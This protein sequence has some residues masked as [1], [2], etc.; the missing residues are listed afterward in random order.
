MHCCVCIGKGAGTLEEQKGLQSISENVSLFLSEQNIHKEVVVIER[1]L[2]KIPKCDFVFNLCDNHEGYP[3]SFI[4]FTEYLEQLQIPYTGNK[5]SCFKKCYDKFLWSNKDKLKDFLPER[6]CTVSEGVFFSGILKHRYF[7]GSLY[8]IK[9][10]NSITEGNVYPLLQTG[11]YFYETFI[12]GKEV[13][14][15]VLPK[16]GYAIGEQKQLQDSILN[17]ENKWHQSPEIIKPS[18][19]K[20]SINDIEKIIKIVQQEF[21]ITSYMRL[22]LRIDKHKRVFLIDI[23]PNCSLDPSG[24]FSRV[25]SLYNV[26][27]NEIL[28]EITSNFQGTYL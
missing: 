8:P 12:P 24:S 18:L 1:Y 2:Q 22:D 4:F 17:F 15:S 16:K 6:G 28:S 10:F 19:T 13:T 5:S 27:Y 3:D 25:F 21:D 14:V 7:H 11:N 26:T 20:E 9:K 23:N